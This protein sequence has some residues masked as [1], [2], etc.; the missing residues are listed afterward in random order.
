MRRPL[1][2]LLLVL[3]PAIVFGGVGE[4]FEDDVLEDQDQGQHDKEVGGFNGHSLVLDLSSLGLL[5]ALKIKFVVV[6]LVALAVF[7]LLTKGY[8]TQCL[9]GNCRPNYSTYGYYPYV[10]Y[11]YM[12]YELP[13]NAA[14]Y[15]RPGSGGVA[16]VQGVPGVVAKDSHHLSDLTARVWNSIDLANMAFGALNIQEEDCRRKLV[17]QADRAA[18]SN[19]LLRAAM[20]W[21][22][23]ARYRADRPRLSADQAGDDLGGDASVQWRQEDPCEEMYPLC[24]HRDLPAALGGPSRP[25]V[26][27]N[28]HHD[29]H[30]HH[31][32]PHQ[33]LDHGD[34][35]PGQVVDLPTEQWQPMGYRPEYQYTFYP[36][37]SPA[38]GSTYREPIREP[39]REE[40]ESSLTSPSDSPVPTLAATS[41]HEQPSANAVLGPDLPDLILGSATATSASV[42][43]GGHDGHDGATATSTSTTTSTSTPWLEVSTSTTASENTE[44]PPEPRAPSRTN[45]DPAG[46]T[47]GGTE[48]PKAKAGANLVWRRMHFGATASSNRT[49][50]HAD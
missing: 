22:N 47:A 30:H 13:A 32:Q 50:L 12:G 11:T 49:K 19:P 15:R 4:A 27:L 36:T 46:G 26:F 45:V 28:H 33:H 20:S 37:Y 44:S 21:L 39:F 6:L 35:G 23:L 42:L 25:S 5:A 34:H 8:K 3:L 1:A 43:A 38:Y 40:D 2:A 14:A 29:L 17:C 16:V 9:F 10:D 41:L 7:L 31:H 18:A 48:P 24:L